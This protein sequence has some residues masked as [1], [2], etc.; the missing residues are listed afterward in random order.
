MFK[1]LGAKVGSKYRD[2]RGSVQLRDTITKEVGF[3]QGCSQEMFFG[4]KSYIT[5]H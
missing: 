4:H 2:R 3:T 5:D 1:Y